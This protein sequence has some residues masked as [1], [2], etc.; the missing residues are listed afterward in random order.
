MTPKL[1]II[2]VNY[3]SEDAL[4]HCLRSL[5]VASNE[6]L[7]VIL[8][9]NSPIGPE[10]AP[11]NDRSARDVLESSGVQGFY[12]PQPENLGYTTA[13]NIGARHAR[14]EF[15]CFLNPDTVLGQHTLDRMLAWVHQHPRTVAGPRE[16]DGN[17]RILTTAFP[18]VTRRHIWGANFLYKLPWP[19]SWHPALPWLVPP[20]RYARLCRTAKEPKRV[21][22]LSGSCLLMTKRV[23]EEV[24][25]WA[26]HLSYFGLESEWF[27]RAREFG[28]TAWYLPNAGMYHE[29]GLSIRRGSAWQV[30]A[31]ADRNRRWHAR[32]KGWWVLVILVAVLWFEH[33][34]HETRENPT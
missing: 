12:F 31:E 21:P 7:E 2:I 25:E 1:S 32:R 19:R 30:H 29:H 10:Y 15:L 14:G 28:V 11:K 4:E 34:L 9:D 8:I 6:S 26:T 22:V 33:R 27:E 3:R 24:G 13:A 20:H 23:W 18:Y 17:D 16:R 5:H